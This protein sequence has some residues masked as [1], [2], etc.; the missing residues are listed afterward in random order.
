MATRKKATG[1]ALLFGTSAKRTS[2]LVHVRTIVESVAEALGLD[3]PVM[4]SRRRT[5]YLTEA[6]Y[7]AAFLIRARLH[8]GAREIAFLIGFQDHTTVLDGIK[9]VSRRARANAWRG[10][11]DEIDRDSLRRFAQ[12]AG[13]GGHDDD[14]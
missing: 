7:V 11:I 12:A 3:V 2:D 14:R 8:L 5:W 10:F 1:P 6:R 13:S 4:L 9:Q